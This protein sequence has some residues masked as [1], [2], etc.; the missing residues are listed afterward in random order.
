MRIAEKSS[1]NAISSTSTLPGLAMDQRYV[2]TVRACKAILRNM[3]HLEDTITYGQ[4]AELSRLLHRLRECV[5]QFL[6]ADDTDDGLWV[7]E[8]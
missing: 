1:D 6:E 7:G 4:R 2:D 8:R 3:D 5:D